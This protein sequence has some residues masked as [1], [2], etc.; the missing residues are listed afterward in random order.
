MAVTFLGRTIDKIGVIGSGNI[1]PDIALHFAL[2]LGTK[3]VRVVVVDVSAPALDA[4]Q[5]RVGKKVGKLS[6]KGALDAQKAQAVLGSLI[7]TTDYDELAGAGLV[8]EAASESLPVKQ[9]IY[10]QL[11]SILE[12]KAVLASNT[13]HLPPDVIFSKL[14]HPERALVAHYF[15]P[16]ERNPVVELVTFEKTAEDA[17]RFLELLYEETG[18]IPVRLSSRFG[19][20]VNPV[21]EGMVL[22]SIL[23]VE[24]GV[25]DPLQ[26]D[27]VACQE[28]GYGVG[29]FTA[30]N[31]TGGN[32]LT[33]AALPEYGRLVMP[34]FRSPA[35]LAEKVEKREPWPVAERGQIVEVPQTVRDRV[36]DALLG[37]FFGLNAEIVGSGIID[38]GSQ[39]LAVTAALVVKPPFAFMNELGSERAL[40]LVE[41]YASAQEGFLVPQILRDQAATGRPWEIPVVYRRDE[42][43]VAVLTLRRPLALNA[44]DASVFDQLETHL[45]AIKVDEG[46]VGAVVTGFGTKAFAAGADIKELSR[47]QDPAGLEAKSR[48][49][50]AV[51]RGI[52]TLG[53]PV[54]AAM[55]GFAF[56]GGLELC[57]ACTSRLGR[58]GQKVFAGQ[59]EPKLGVVPGYGGT[60]RLPRIVGLEAAWPILLS[61]EPISSSE[62]LSIGLIDA[63][64]PGPELLSSAV[65]RCRALAKEEVR[66]SPKPEGPI[67]I[68]GQL[69][70]VPLGHL[71]RRID[72]ILRE[73]ILEGARGDLVR[74][75]DL[76]ARAFM[77]CH[78]TKDFHIGIRTFLEQGAKAKAPFVH[79]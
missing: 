28:L 78:T 30:M 51:F 77:L 53:K 48:R 35:T 31:L 34:W 60:Q 5:K 19:F 64:V 69:P 14:G 57:L 21:F 13:S 58:A 18:K 29:P 71:S 49:G 1:G 73:L 24:E 67:Q 7:F 4:G 42:G 3:G 62:A 11:E 15:F 56:G 65:A 8:V 54:V 41:G 27:A 75:L 52:E 20:A 76:E 59:P 61:G 79:E 23:L 6:Q 38:V 72:S 68:P 9:A 10:A 25:A 36:R 33:H 40:A 46:I 26:V 43:D 22:A 74:G 17:V 45:N 12:P 50:Q 2:S 47:I 55:N 44:L 66:P 16:A 39:E 37:V 32:P 70:E 63:E